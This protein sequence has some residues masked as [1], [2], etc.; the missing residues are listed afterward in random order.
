MSDNPSAPTG[1]PTF[2]LGMAPAKTAVDPVCGMTVDPDA[3]RGGSLAHAGTTYH[4]CSESCRGKFAAE[5]G[6]YLAGKR[7]P[8]DLASRASDGTG[9]HSHARGS[10]VKYVCPMDPDVVSDRPGPCPKCGMALEPATPTAE[11]P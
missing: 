5:P 11:E 1:G 3:P 6:T 7:E 2:S 4:F 8:M 10:Q 9:S